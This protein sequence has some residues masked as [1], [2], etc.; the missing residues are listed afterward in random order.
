MFLEYAIICVAAFFAGAVNSIAG[1]GTLLTFPALM[2]SLRNYPD[3]DKIANATST[4]ALM[5]GSF[6]SAWAYRNELIPYR[7]WLMRLLIPSLLGGAV[8]ATFLLLGKND[9]FSKLIPWLILTATLLFVL[10][11]QITRWSGIGHAESEPTQK[12][13]MFV[14]IFQ[15]FR[16]CVRRLLWRGDWDPYAQRHQHLWV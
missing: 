11:P 14:M 5:P 16:Q 8:G 1:G 2:Y 10:Q 3:H 9:T 13:I 4:M 6:A 15:F 7:P 12:K